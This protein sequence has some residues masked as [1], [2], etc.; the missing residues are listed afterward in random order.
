MNKQVNG[1]QCIITWYVDDFKIL[2]VYGKIVEDTINIIDARYSKMAV[3]KSKKHIYVG[4]YILTLLE[5]GRRSYNKGN[6]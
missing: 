2:H 3:T 4:I 5:T 1:K 6:T